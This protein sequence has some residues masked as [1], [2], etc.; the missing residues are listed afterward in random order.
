MNN[1]E[2]LNEYR[3]GD[4]LTQ[5]VSGTQQGTWIVRGYRKNIFYLQ[6]IFRNVH[7]AREFAQQWVTK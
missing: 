7:S 1:T 2:L 6:E 4:K 3:Q 5:V